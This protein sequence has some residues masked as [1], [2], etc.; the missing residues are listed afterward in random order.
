VQAFKTS[1]RS[2]SLFD[3]TSASPAHRREAAM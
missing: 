1:Y 2:G 3:Q